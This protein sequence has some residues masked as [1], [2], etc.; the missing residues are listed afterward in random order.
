MR[1]S[2]VYFNVL[3]VACLLGKVIVSVLGSVLQMSVISEVQ[4]KVFM[5]F[6]THR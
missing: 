4:F 5:V 6:F 2:S 1:T 3:Y